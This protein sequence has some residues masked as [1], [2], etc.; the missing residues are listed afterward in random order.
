MALWNLN[1][2]YLKIS[3]CTHF[4]SQ[5]DYDEVILQA[6][7]KKIEPSVNQNGFTLA[8]H[9]NE[10]GWYEARIDSGGTYKIFQY[11][12]LKANRGENPFVYYY[13]R[14]Y[15]SHSNRR[16]QGKYYPMGMQNEQPDSGY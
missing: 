9:V 10:Y 15:S 5:Y 12:A 2:N 6:S 7:I 4:N 8:C 14:R 3:T 1:L 11:D 13:R 16:W